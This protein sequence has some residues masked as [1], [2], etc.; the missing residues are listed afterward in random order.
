[1]P[2][3]ILFA[4]PAVFIVGG[5]AQVLAAMWSFRKGDTLA[6]TAFG[7]FGSFN[8]L[9]AWQYWLIP[10][11]L[12]VGPTQ[13]FADFGIAIACF[14]LIAG[15]VMVAA[16][17]C[18]L[19]LVGVFGWLALAYGLEAAG[20][21]AGLAPNLPAFGGWAGLVASLLAF[22]TA[23]ALVINSEARRRVLPLGRPLLQPAEPP[24]PTPTVA[25]R[26]EW[27]QREGA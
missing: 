19:A 14:A 11:R 22:Y 18:N 3:D 12:M 27:Q 16:L 9:F 2:T 7:A 1:L 26:P 6:A 8:V 17:W 15:G 25:E 20:I 5:I 13:G 24:V 4:L 10:T 21:I 23:G